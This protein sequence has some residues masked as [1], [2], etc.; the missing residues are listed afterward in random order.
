[1]AVPMTIDMQ[2]NRRQVV[3]M[4]RSGHNRSWRRPFAE[5]S[6]TVACVWRN[7]FVCSYHTL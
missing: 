1:M 2:M 6:R 7:V 3:R 4:L 5:Q